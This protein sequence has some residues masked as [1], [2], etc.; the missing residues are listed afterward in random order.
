M[1]DNPWGVIG[2]I[3][4]IV[5]VVLVVL[6]LFRKM[7]MNRDPE[8]AAQQSQRM[9]SRNLARQQRKVERAQQ[10]VKKAKYNEA[11]APA[12]ATL[13]KAKQEY[14]MRV[15][16]AEDNVRR[17]TNAR[18][19]SIR[20]QERRIN[21]IGKKYGEHLES[22]GAV[23]L[24]AD[25]IEVRGVSI[26]LNST[27]MADMMQGTDALNNRSG[28]SQFHFVKPTG[29]GEK[30][31]SPGSL[32]GGVGVP[33][34]PWEI[35]A[36]PD[37]CYLFIQGTAQEYGNKQVLLCIPLDDRNLDDGDAF[38]KKLN[39]TARNAEAMEEQRVAEL[40]AAQAE[41]ERLQADMSAVDEANRQLQN[42]RA[43]NRAVVEAQN[44][45]DETARQAREE[46]DYKP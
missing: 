3:I 7:K 22:L 31:N 46:L 19:K 40:G 28:R 6:Y 43:D 32:I 4:V 24:F 39:E 44:N 18:E 41:L 12:K 9:A 16:K 30:P 17:V 10:R 2:T 1:G 15:K 21:D 38:M 27:F 36:Q 29:E 34:I 5:V 20:E 45:L 8:F 37:F 35:K 13:N 33:E 23:R 25:R 42:E 26:A 11:I 14:N